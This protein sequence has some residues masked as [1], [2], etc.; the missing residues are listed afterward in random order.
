M[1]TSLIS[2]SKIRYRPGWRDRAVDGRAVE[3]HKYANKS[4]KGD[5]H[6]GVVEEGTVG[7]VETK[8]LSYGRVK[9]LVF[10]NFGDHGNQQGE[11]GYSTD[12]QEGSY[13]SR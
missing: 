3:L 13:E 6:Y 12:W 4:R 8:L 11:G 1:D 2:V 9:G 10:G 5:Q 7:P